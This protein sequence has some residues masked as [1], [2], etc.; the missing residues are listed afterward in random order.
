[1]VFRHSPEPP[2]GRP[3]PRRVLY[4]CQ[5]LP[6]PIRN[7]HDQ[8]VA[9]RLRALA[10]AGVAMFLVGWAGWV[11]SGGRSGGKAVGAG[12]VAGGHVAPPVHAGPPADAAP[13]AHA[14]SLATLTPDWRA[15]AFSRGL[16]RRLLQLPG[17]IGRPAPVLTR[18]VS[19]AHYS[20]ILAAA[21][22]FAPGMVFIDGL[23]AADLGRRL[24]RDLH[25]TYAYRA[26]RREHDHHRRR[27]RRQAGVIDKL[28]QLGRLQ[29]LRRYERGVLGGALCFLD[30]S[31]DNV[32]TWRAEGFEHGEWLPPLQALPRNDPRVDGRPREPAG[33]RPRAVFDVGVI[34]GPCVDDSVTGVRW[35]LTDVMPRV[36]LL[37]PDALCAVAVPHDADALK[38]AL[39][40]QAGVRILPDADVPTMYSH[41]RVL[42]NASRS[43]AGAV[44]QMADA[45]TTDRPIVS[46][47]EGV[48]GLPEEVRRCIAVAPDAPQFAAAVLRALDDP[49][50]DLAA[51]ATQRR[52]FGPQ[53][54]HEMMVSLSVRAA[55]R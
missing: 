37:R 39:A 29:G 19:G 35:L 30:I 21:R 25:L 15:L 27:L 43:P 28:R 5:E 33:A 4:V 31:V 45:L 50:I 3:D 54:I 41:C 12:A 13:P 40:G 52:R 47:P 14:H 24:A 26:H 32:E 36:R 42:V 6:Y 53:A 46:T 44:V 51:R 1:M 20:E 2:P 23:F 49:A 18:T 11:E 8:D 17:A 7:G 55:L 16:R 9:R 10:D 34:A 22:R 48:F 38:A